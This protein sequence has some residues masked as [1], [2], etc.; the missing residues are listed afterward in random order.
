MRDETDGPGSVAHH[1][2]KRGTSIGSTCRIPQN[3]AG[4]KWKANDQE[5]GEVKVA[6]R[7]VAHP[8]RNK[9]LT[10]SSTGSGARFT[11]ST[12]SPIAVE[13]EVAFLQELVGGN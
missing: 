5:R 7:S 6:D 13:Y 12:P 11:F 4:P 1:F 2:A 8:S 10:P 3:V 9:P